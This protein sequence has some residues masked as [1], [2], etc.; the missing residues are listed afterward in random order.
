MGHRAGTVRG[1]RW[2]FRDS[3]KQREARE[4]DIR[5]MSGWRYALD[6]FSY[7]SGKKQL[8]DSVPIYLCIYSFMAVVLNCI[9]LSVTWLWT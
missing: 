6:S 9:L 2:G 7:P 1:V 5:T 3:D 8:K 4:E